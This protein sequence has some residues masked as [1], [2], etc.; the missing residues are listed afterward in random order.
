MVNAFRPDV[1]ND[2]TRLT[3]EQALAMAPESDGVYFKVPPALDDE[4]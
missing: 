4:S 3:R 2:D 1:V